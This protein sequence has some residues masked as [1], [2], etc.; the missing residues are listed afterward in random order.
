ME[1]KNASPL[2]SK[3]K[4]KMKRQLK[5]EKHATTEKK[6]KE[7]P[8]K[9]GKAQTFTDEQF[10]EALKKI[11]HAATSREISDTLGIKEA[12]SGRALVRR[13]MAKLAE[14]GKIKITETPKGKRGRLY[15][16]V[17]S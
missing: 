6:P 7:K 10:V 4:P 8:Q 16:L 3:S 11:G 17:K 5:T 13:V 1:M 12:E 15:D 2:D 9:R 14:D